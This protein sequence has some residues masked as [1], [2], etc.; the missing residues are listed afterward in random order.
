[1]DDLRVR[2]FP[3]QVS[4]FSGQPVSAAG[5][6]AAMASPVGP[7]AEPTGAGAEGSRGAGKWAAESFEDAAASLARHFQKPGAE[8]GATDVAQY[9]SKARAFADH[10]LRARGFQ[11]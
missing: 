1:M 3:G 9:L 10:L 7:A 6:G 5:K 4:G 8:V 2:A 11:A